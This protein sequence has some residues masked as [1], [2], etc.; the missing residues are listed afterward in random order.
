MLTFSSE[1]RDH[2]VVALVRPKWGFRM[3]LYCSLSQCCSVILALLPNAG[4]KRYE[5]RQEKRQ[6]RWDIGEGSRSWQG[7]QR[8]T[9]KL[10]RGATLHGATLMEMMDRSA[11][12]S[13]YDG[14]KEE[15]VP[16]YVERRSLHLRNG[17]IH[18]HVAA[19]KKAANYA[20]TL[21]I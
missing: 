20:V 13:M 6:E 8:P 18:V 12:Y 5:K 7:L 1:G 3:S 10:L 4:R 19:K 2:Y 11:R 14:N 15:M 16:L 9:G 17:I 21:G